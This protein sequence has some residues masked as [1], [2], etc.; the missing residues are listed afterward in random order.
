ML[1]DLPHGRTLVL[2]GGS[3]LAFGCYVILVPR[4]PVPVIFLI[5]I[6]VG[7]S[8]AATTAPLM[9]FAGERFEA[10][11]TARVVALMAT[12]AQ[13]GATLAGVVFGFLL[14]HGNRFQL[15]WIACAA[16][17]LIRLV[18]LVPFFLHRRDAPLHGT[19]IRDASN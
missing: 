7:V 15:I 1:A 10:S 19:L 13:I 16:L 17:S 5:T 18:M 3:A 4:E 2:L 14:A 8:L 6:L 11:E 9:L 12:V